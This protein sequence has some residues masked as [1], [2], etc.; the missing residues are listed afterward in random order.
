MNPTTMR[1]LTMASAK[2]LLGQG[3]ITKPHHAKIMKNLAAPAMAS[4]KAPGAMAPGPKLP[5][6]RPGAPQAGG[7]QV[8]MGALDASQGQG[9]APMNPLDQA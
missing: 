4:M 7:L 2:H 1:N 9:P 5:A 6:M 8:P 3:H